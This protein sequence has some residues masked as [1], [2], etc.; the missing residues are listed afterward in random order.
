MAAGSLRL[1]GGRE[2]PAP[3]RATAHTARRRHTRTRVQAL[4]AKLKWATC[5]PCTMPSTIGGEHDFNPFLRAVAAVPSIVKCSGCA[6]PA[7]AIF[8]VRKNKDAWGR[9]SRK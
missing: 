8:W 2:L 1:A 5:Q 6:D 3:R 4:Q 9:R 7:D